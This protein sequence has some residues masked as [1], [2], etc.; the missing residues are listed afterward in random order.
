M[1]RGLP[2]TVGWG[3]DLMQLN[4]KHNKRLVPFAKQLRKDMTKEE[5]RLWYDFLRDYPLKFLRQKVIGNYIADFYCAKAKLVIELDGSQH[6]EDNNVT[7]DL[8]RTEFLEQYG[9]LVVRIP[10]NYLNDNFEY[11]CEYIDHI[12]KER[13]G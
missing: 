12:V 7:K 10:N 11:A 5:K 9:L 1:Q 2:T 4:K 8:I 3:I 6:Y 13:I